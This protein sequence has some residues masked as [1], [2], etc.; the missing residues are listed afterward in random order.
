VSVLLVGIDMTA[1]NVA[2]PSI[3]RDFHVGASGLSWI[4]ELIEP[5]PSAYGVGSPASPSRSARSSAVPSLGHRSGG[6]GS[7]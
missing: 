5:R 4:I 3:G 7:S 2:L 1:V 6:D